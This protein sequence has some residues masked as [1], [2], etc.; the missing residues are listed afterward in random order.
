M[1]PTNYLVCILFLTLTKETQS[2][3]L[4]RGESLQLN[5]KETLAT[6]FDFDLLSLVVSKKCA[7]A[8]IGTAR[9]VG[10]SSPTDIQIC[11]VIFRN[12]SNNNQK[13][14]AYMLKATHFTTK[15]TT[16]CQ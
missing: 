10:D 6:Y 4:V 3:Y 9:S 5:I 11:F 2:I 12:N 8:S 7:F 14:T 16:N 13:S 1:I 15:F